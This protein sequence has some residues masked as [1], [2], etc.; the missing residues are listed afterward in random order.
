MSAWKSKSATVATASTY[1]LIAFALAKV[2]SLA[3]T[4][5]KSVSTLVIAVAV[6]MTNA[7]KFTVPSK[8]AFLNSK[9]AVPKSI[10][11][12]VDGTIAPS[13]IINCS[14]DTPPTSI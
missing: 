12:S 6:P 10:S 13:W 11:L 3:D 2:S 7:S 14:V 8:Y 9:A 4:E 5:V 1:V